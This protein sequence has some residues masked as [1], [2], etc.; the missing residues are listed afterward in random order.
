MT[1]SEEI[2]KQVDVPDVVRSV[3]KIYSP[4]TPSSPQVDILPRVSMEAWEMLGDKIKHKVNKT[5]TINII[6][7][8]NIF[9]CKYQ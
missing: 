9:R 3:V 1:L 7:F 4:D 6:F 5:P 2:T 8:L